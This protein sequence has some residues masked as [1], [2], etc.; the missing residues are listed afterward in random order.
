MLFIF[1]LNSNLLKLINLHFL[2][3]VYNVVTVLLGDNNLI[4]L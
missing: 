1:Y 4:T 2:A 3:N